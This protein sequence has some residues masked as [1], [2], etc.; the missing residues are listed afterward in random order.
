M[1]VC[2]LTDPHKCQIHVY[3]VSSHTVALKILYQIFSD[4]SGMKIPFILLCEKRDLVS[5]NK[6]KSFV[7]DTVNSCA[8]R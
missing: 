2:M 6:G 8:G 1:A 7:V 5:L 3:L 4:I